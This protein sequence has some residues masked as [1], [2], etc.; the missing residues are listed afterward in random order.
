M[1]TETFKTAKNL[2]VRIEKLER[3]R[4]IATNPYLFYIGMSGNTF[5]MESS[6]LD[7][8]FIDYLYQLT[9]EHIESSIKESQRL[10]EEL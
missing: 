6:I 3:L 7:A 1:T 5:N 8:T 4:E 2:I 10:L 9:M